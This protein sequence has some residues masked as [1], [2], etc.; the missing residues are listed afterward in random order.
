MRVDPD[1]EVA[2]GNGTLE[3]PAMAQVPVIHDNPPHPLEPWRHDHRAER[4]AA[5]DQVDP[6]VGRRTTRAI[7]AMVHNE[8][9][10][11]PI[12]LAYYSRYFGPGDIYVLDHD[13][14]DGSTAGDGFVRMPVH[15]DGF[16]NEWQVATVEKLQRELL[17]RYD[18]VVVTDVDEIIVPRPRMGDL[19]NYLDT[20]AE[21]FVS[22][23][24]YEV[25]H[26]PD[27][28]PP[29]DPSRPVLEQRSYWSENAVYNKSSLTTEPASWVPGFHRRSDLQFRSEP[30]LFLI[31]LHRVDYE[32]CRER[33]QRWSQRVWSDTDLGAE[34]GAQ[35]RVTGGERFDRW[36]FTESSFDGFPLRIERIPDEWRGIF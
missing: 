17:E 24:G 1:H 23:M 28:E 10:F 19:G 27:R 30:D 7:I 35:N 26:L 8:P 13:T 20:F 34:W 22:C 2:Q 12:W 11:F 36:F 21:P 33:H 25:V 32:L 6:E 29:F 4:Q 18:I 15:R 3:S 14:D 31:H 5:R 9:V 16:D